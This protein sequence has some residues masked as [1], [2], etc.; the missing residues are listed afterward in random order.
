MQCH[1]YLF[2]ILKKVLRPVELPYVYC[3][4]N[5]VYKLQMVHLFYMLSN[6][7]SLLRYTV[8]LALFGNLIIV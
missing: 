1:E 2:D 7:A 3:G 6:P 5:I 4:V 8:Y